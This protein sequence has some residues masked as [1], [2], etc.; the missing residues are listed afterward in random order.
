MGP[1]ELLLR[2]KGEVVGEE[3]RGVEEGEKS[4]KGGRGV[5]YFIL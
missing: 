3:R 2:G 1:G 4:G 5:N